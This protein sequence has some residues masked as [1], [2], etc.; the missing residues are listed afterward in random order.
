[1]WICSIKRVA[2]GGG[3]SCGAERVE[4]VRDYQRAFLCD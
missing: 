2:D 3:G 4:G 1:M